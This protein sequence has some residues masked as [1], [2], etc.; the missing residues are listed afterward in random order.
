MSSSEPDYF[1][2]Q[3]QHTRPHCTSS[4]HPHC[5]YPMLCVLLQ[6]ASIVLQDFSTLVPYNSIMTS[7]SLVKD[8]CKEKSYNFL[9]AICAY[10]EFEDCSMLCP[11]TICCHVFHQEC[12]DLW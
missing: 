4:I 10:L 8:R 3:P 9:Y 12:I 5:P 7:G 11:L 6:L 1:I 2:L